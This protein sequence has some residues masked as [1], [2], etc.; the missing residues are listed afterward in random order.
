VSRAGKRLDAV[1]ANVSDLAAI[2][3]A[4]GSIFRAAD[5]ETV[6]PAETEAIRCRFSRLADRSIGMRAMEKA[7]E[8]IHQRLLTSAE[9]RGWAQTIE[10]TLGEAEALGLARWLLAGTERRTFTG[11]WKDARARVRALFARDPAEPLRTLAGELAAM[12]GDDMIPEPFTGLIGAIDGLRELADPIE[13]SFDRK[14][15][16]RAELFGAPRPGDLA[17][18]DAGDVAAPGASS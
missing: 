14:D 5:G 4:V 16:Q 11:R 10:A 18:P 7:V 9:G 12:V 15:R 1:T 2:R 3:L 8:L 6:D 17:E 13:A